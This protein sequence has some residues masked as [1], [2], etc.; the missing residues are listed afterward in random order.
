VRLFRFSLLGLPRDGQ[1]TIA[2]DPS[3]LSKA[4]L[5]GLIASGVAPNPEVFLIANDTK[6]PLSDQFNVG[7]R[8]YIRGVL[9]SANYAGIRA[10]NGFT[11]LFGNR[12][13]DGTCCIGIPGFSN[14][15]ISSDDKKNWFDALYLTAE[16]PF[17]N[18]WGF[19]VNYT[20]GK[21]EA[22]GGDLFSLDYPTVEAYPRHPAATDERHRIV[23]TGIVGVPGDVILSTFMTFASG[24]GYTIS[25]NSQGSG[26]NERQI[27]LFAGR[28][29]D[30]F[31][32][33]SVD[34]R[35]EKLFRFSN[36]TASVA[37]EAF[38][39]FN[40]T[41]FTDYDG[42]IPV[43]PLVNP[44]YGQPRSTVDNSSRRLQFGVRYVF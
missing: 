43:L 12:R 23:G 5:D 3:Y 39:I 35:V 7:V 27:L 33:K 44:T 11:F 40:W 22:I 37:F 25:D 4:G 24:L 17:N 31:N 6:P 14:I 13:P 30:T 18:R 41:N 34:F 1:A 36:Q 21:A 16:K 9:V 15:L 2:W 29:P 8:T 19:R 10:R 26:P 38:N 42:F 20:L 28:P 32:Y